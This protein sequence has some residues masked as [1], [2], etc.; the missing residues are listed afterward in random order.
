MHPLMIVPSATDVTTVAPTA[1]AAA[2]QA[3]KDAAA[4]AKMEHVVSQMAAESGCRDSINWN[5][6][7]E[8]ALLY[9]K[10]IEAFENSKSK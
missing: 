5:D 4:R 2:K 6:T 3:A 9:N 10:A 7:V 1:A 8:K